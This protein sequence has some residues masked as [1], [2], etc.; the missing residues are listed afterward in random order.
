MIIVKCKNTAAL[1]RCKIMFDVP[2]TPITDL[3]NTQTLTLHR[4][5]HAL[6]R[7]YSSVQIL[8]EITMA[9]FD[10]DYRV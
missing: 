7:L 6:W 9:R 2:T 10:Q 8:L 3:H 1:H 5:A 4:P